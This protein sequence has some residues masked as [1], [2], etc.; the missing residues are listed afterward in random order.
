LNLTKT[1]AAP[2]APT[3][4]EHPPESRREQLLRA[5]SRSR[6]R[7]IDRDVIL[8]AAMLALAAVASIASAPA[9]GVSTDVVALVTFSVLVIAGLGQVGLYRPR[10]APHFFDDARKIIGVTAIVAMAMTFMRVL[11][12]DNPQAAAQAARAWVFASVYLIAARGGRHLI[13]M[14]QRRAGTRGRRTMIVGAGNVGR[15]FAQRLLERPDFGLRPVAFLDDDP[16]EVE[17]AG[18]HIPVLDS[19]REPGSGSDMFGPRLEEAIAKLRIA[20]VVVSFSTTSH[21]AELDLVRRCQAMGVSVSVLP[22]LFEGVT[23]RLDLER[24]GGMAIISVH[25]TDPDGWQF[26][27]KYGIDRVFAAIA[28][29]VTSPLMIVAA[30][31]TLATLGRPIIFRQ[32]RVG[33]DGKEFD[34]L[35][36]RTMRLPKPGELTEAEVEDRMALGLGPGGVEGADR[37]TAVGSFLRRSSIDELPQLLNVLRGDMSIVGPRPERPQF[38]RMFDESIYRYA[39]RNRVKSG[40]TGWSQVNGLRGKT[41]IAQRAEWDNYYIENRSFWLDMKILALTLPAVLRH[42]E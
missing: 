17:N 30:L 28:L 34:V 32:A 10:F 41:S 26:A 20:H 21:S 29:I 8:D 27:V 1:P 42:R 5:A 24:I 33:L 11:I 12:F 35:K 19:G 40:I 7:F 9:A 38:A 36:F 2:A 37:R 23:D 14:K 25:P 6:R 4:A 3:A 31:L 18:A 39:D 15:E 22:R 13:E 16:L